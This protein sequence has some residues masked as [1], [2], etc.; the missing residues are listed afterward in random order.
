VEPFWYASRINKRL[1]NRLLLDEE[2]I[3]DV[4]REERRAA[5]NPPSLKLVP[6]RERDLDLQLDLVSLSY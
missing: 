3:R 1:K 4:K 5:L 6:G 2:T